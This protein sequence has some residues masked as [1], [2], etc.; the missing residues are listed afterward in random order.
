MLKKIIQ[1]FSKDESSENKTTQPPNVKSF[2]THLG[3]LPRTAEELKKMGGQYFNSGDLVQAE[4]YY[5]QSHDVD[6]TL[7]GVCKILGVIKYYQ[8]ELEDAIR[9]YDHELILK[10]DCSETHSNRGLALNDLNRLEEALI[11]LDRAIEL[12]PDFAFAYN[13]RGMVL[14]SL[15]RLE[16]ALISYDRAI[17][18]K[19]DFAQAYNNRGTALSKLKR[20]QEALNGF[21]RAI[22]L[23]PDYVNALLNQG[24]VLVNLNRLDE[25]LNSYE[26]AVSIKPDFALAYS[27]RSVALSRLGRLEESLDSVDHA[28]SLKPDLQEAYKGRGAA[29]KGLNR[30]ED[31]LESFDRAI[32]L[33]A[34]D[35]E[36]H[37]DRGSVLS[38][39]KRYVE[40]LKS[41]ER[42]IEIE[43][44]HEY[45]YGYWLECKQLLCDWSDYEL[46]LKSL[47][48][49]INFGKNS[50]A[51]LVVLWYVS[52]AVLQKKAA[53]N[54]V[55]PSY[56]SSDLLPK[57]VPHFERDKIRLGY[58]SGDFRN[59]PV[60]FL[61]AEL[62]EKH[63]KSKFELIAFSFSNVEQ[64]MTKRITCAFDRFI[65][66]SKRSD[67]EVAL[68]ARE[69]E[70]DIA[71]DLGGFTDGG[72]AGIFAM[73]AAPVQVNYLGFPGTMGAD[74]M[75]YIIADATIIPVSHQQ[76]YAEK[77]AYL[78]S[79]Q[80]NDTK[81]LISD[82][83]FTR[84]ELGLPSNCFVFCCF[85]NITKIGPLNF[86]SWMRILQQV[87]G[88]VLWLL[89][90]NPTAV[91]NLRKEAAAR[92]VDSSRLIFAKR[93]TF[94]DYLAR[95]RMAD[96]FLDTLPFNAGTTA[97]DAL[98]AGLPVITQMGES[99]AGR[100]AASLLNAIQLPELITTTQE[101]Y[102][103]LAVE[104]ALNPDKLA[105][106]KQKL[107]K[108]RLTT[109]L[110]DI[111]Y[112]TKHIE[113]AYAQMYE[114]SQAGLEP[115]H[116]SA[117]EEPPRES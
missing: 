77:V 63:D 7:Y 56:P 97:S 104:L 78:P 43:P 82:R 8:G 52:S 98:W 106:V 5:K 54:F 93:E 31:A 111:D 48:E 42:A 26:R 68:M 44:D 11:S 71:I 3:E 53:E 37:N 70:I 62:F 33:K 108:N 18:L 27:Y 80:V 79:F 2:T 25:A 10:P 39:L 100:M 35:S 30:L 59:H 57:L 73:R 105:E 76:Y 58:F 103:T 110:F 84:E 4:I 83:K 102:E 91:N 112:F 55:R 60:S 66:V 90:E 14:M 51:L 13:N 24:G 85:N 28:I 117:V 96:L 15:N 1:L 47:E 107:A 41:H 92:G 9:H 61:I 72:R 23:K 115:D 113:A 99:F 89:D 116:I 87:E 49:K 109:P 21:E 67:Q 86:D 81:R 16:E 75:D 29:L 94:P 34:D 88:S 45:F 65:D 95:Y 19:P 69:L 114:R 36:A 101:D 46:R 17:S 50:T 6:P 22:L 32:L 20:Q 38:N 12:K 40:A 64:D 74:F